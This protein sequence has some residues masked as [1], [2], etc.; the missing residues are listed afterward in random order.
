MI[1]DL[2]DRN[3]AQVAI[4][5]VTGQSG[6]IPM[7]KNFFSFKPSR[8]TIQPSDSESLF[9]FA[10]SE[11]LE[12]FFELPGHIIG[13][14]NTSLGSNE[15]EAFAE[16]VGLTGRFPFGIIVFGGRAIRTAG[17]VARRRIARRAV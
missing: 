9:A 10:E 12:S 13:Q 2:T 17:R 3:R 4:L 8:T 7:F 14:I 15:L 1:N 5:H 16:N 11:G 6:Y